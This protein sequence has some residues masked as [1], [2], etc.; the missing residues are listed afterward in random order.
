MNDEERRG[1]LAALCELV[2]SAHAGRCLSRTYR[3]QAYKYSFACAHGHEFVASA[4]NVIHRGSW[5]PTCAGNACVDPARV[6]SHVAARGGR[7]LPGERVPNADTPVRVECG[8]GHRFTLHPRDCGTGPRAWC[9]ECLE[10]DRRRAARDALAADAA[11][12]GHA[13]VSP[14]WLGPRVEHDF[15]CPVGHRWSATPERFRLRDGA[16]SAC[17]VALSDARPPTG[18]LADV[19]DADAVASRTVLPERW[20]RGAC[21]AALRLLGALAPLL[22]LPRRAHE[23]ALNAGQLRLLV[24]LDA[25]APGRAPG[26]PGGADR[27]LARALDGHEAPTVDARLSVLRAK[28]LVRPMHKG[29][30]R[31]AARHRTTPT[32]RLVVRRLLGG[33]AHHELV[34]GLDR[35]C[36]LPVRAR[37]TPVNVSH[38]SVLARVVAEPGVTLPGIVGGGRRG[39]KPSVRTRLRWLEDR[40]LVERL[41]RFN[42]GGTSHPNRWCATTDGTALVVGLAPGGSA[43]ARSATART[44]SP[45]SASVRRARD[46]GPRTVSGDA[47]RDRP[48]T[49]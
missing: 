12:V 22:G 32:G 21:A 25:A 17:R 7:L 26:S 1:R 44:R 10:I 8:R 19:P 40:G 34:V 35:A 4:T 11:A 3:G 13:L 27:H 20:D 36:A 29:D 24:Q 5:C 15:V 31:T 33:R 37:E 2:A 9:V 23:T 38:L 43:G 14:A 16:C 48:A 41:P 28:G 47:A 42:V 49:G 39:P 46:E 45:R 30:Y 6:H 18:A